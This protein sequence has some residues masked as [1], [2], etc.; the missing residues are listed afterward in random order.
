MSYVIPEK[1]QLN[2]YGIEAFGIPLTSR[3]GIAMEMSQMLRFSY[4]LASAGVGNHIESVFYDSGSCCCNFEFIP[5]FDENS[6]YAEKIKQCALRSIGQF[7]WF[8]MIE[9]GDIN[10]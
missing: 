2:E 8:G 1:G 3:H 7:E 10:G 9:H 5:G 6:V 4:Y